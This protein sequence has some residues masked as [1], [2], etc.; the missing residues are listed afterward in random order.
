MNVTIQSLDDEMDNLHDISSI[1][2][3][4]NNLKI[5]DA[6]LGNF[7]IR[8]FLDV[9]V[10]NY[11][12]LYAESLYLIEKESQV[13]MDGNRR[14]QKIYD[15]TLSESDAIQNNN[16]RKPIL[17]TK[18]QRHNKRYYLIFDKNSNHRIVSDIDLNGND[19]CVFIVYQLASNYAVRNLYAK[20]GMFGHDSGGWDKFVCMFFS[21]QPIG[22]IRCERS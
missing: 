2:K 22:S 17:C 15:V 10:Q 14:V 7:L 6:Y 20:N 5:S 4:N 8:S 12:N 21:L 9:Y 3:E 16:D 19:V 13:V 18:A 1:I 11:I